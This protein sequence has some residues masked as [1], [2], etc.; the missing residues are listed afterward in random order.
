MLVISTAWNRLPVH[1]YFIL[2]K[3][4]VMAA[5]YGA[6]AAPPPHPAF[7]ISCDYYSTES[8]DPVAYHEGV[9]LS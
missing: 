7:H 8:I 5:T 3:M 1:F 9:G 2:L 6:R 4:G